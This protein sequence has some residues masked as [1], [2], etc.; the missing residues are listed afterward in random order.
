M[1][2]ETILLVIGG[3]IVIAI[4]AGAMRSKRNRR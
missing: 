2:I 3:A 4:V 1:G